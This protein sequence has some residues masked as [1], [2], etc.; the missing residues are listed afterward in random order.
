MIYSNENVKYC[1]VVIGICPPKLNEEIRH[2][3]ISKLPVKLV[4]T[5]ALIRKCALT[6]PAENQVSL[7]YLGK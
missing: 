1:M 6:F 5:E 7:G 2:K 3:K 4:R